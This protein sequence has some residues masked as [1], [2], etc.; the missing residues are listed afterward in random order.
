MEGVGR[1]DIHDPMD[2]PIEDDKVF[3]GEDEGDFHKPREDAEVLVVEVVEHRKRGSIE[4]ET[5]F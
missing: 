3:I 4:E 1:E 2:D 5:L